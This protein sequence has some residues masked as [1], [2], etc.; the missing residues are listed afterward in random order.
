MLMAFGILFKISMFV[1][2]A[3][4]TFVLNQYTLPLFLISCLICRIFH[5][6]KPHLGRY[7]LMFYPKW[8][9]KQSAGMLADLHAMWHRPSTKQENALSKIPLEEWFFY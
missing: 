3:T 2:M 1:F 8:S 5:L 9:N 7:G 6:Q 4:W